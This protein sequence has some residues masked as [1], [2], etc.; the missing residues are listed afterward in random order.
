MLYRCRLQSACESAGGPPAV[1]SKRIWAN[2][3]TGRRKAAVPKEVGFK[4]KPAIALEPQPSAREAGL[5]GGAVLLDA[6]CGKN[7]ELRSKITKLGL[8]LRSPEFC[9]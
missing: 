4:T 8:T 3:Q 5:P 6:S 9:R 2:N 7:S 1:S